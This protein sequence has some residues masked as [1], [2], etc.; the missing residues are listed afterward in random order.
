MELLKLQ[1]K[2]NISNSI[3]N[4]IDS[5][6]KFIQRLENIKYGNKEKNDK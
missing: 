5:A 1:K 6:K 2:E 3:E 4:E